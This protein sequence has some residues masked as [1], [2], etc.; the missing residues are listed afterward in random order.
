MSLR[1]RFKMDS[2]P[3]APGRVAPE[4]LPGKKRV[5]SDDNALFSKEEIERGRLQH[6]E[7]SK[8]CSEHAAALQKQQEMK[9]KS[10][11]RAESAAAAGEYIL[12]CK[13]VLNREPPAEPPT[14]VVSTSLK[15]PC[16]R[17]V[18]SPHT[19]VQPLKPLVPVC[20]RLWEED[21][22][23]FANELHRRKAV[24][25]PPDLVGSAL[26]DGAVLEA[27]PTGYKRCQHDYWDNA[28][29][30]KHVA[31]KLRCVA[32]GPKDKLVLQDD[33]GLGAT[34]VAHG[35]FNC[36]YRKAAGVP[37]VDLPSLQGKNEV[38][39]ITRPDL[40]QDGNSRY[41]QECYARRE[42]EISL[43]ASA[44]GIGVHVFAAAIYE[45]VK[46]ARSMKFG[47]F[48][49]LEQAKGD[50]H[51]TLTRVGVTEV[52]AAE[53]AVK[54]VELLFKASQL[55]MVLFDMKP[56]N[57]LVFHDGRV[58]LA[59]FD[60]AFCLV[61]PDEDWR[62]L[63]FINVLLLSCHVR[64]IAIPE[65]CRGW[66]TAVRPL[67]Q[68]MLAR[69]GDYDSSWVFAV[70]CVRLKTD[71]EGSDR[72]RL[73]RMF[74]SLASSYFY[75]SPKSS[76]APS[77][78]YPWKY[79]SDTQLKAFWRENQDS[80]WPSHVDGRPVTPLVEQLVEFALSF[81]PDA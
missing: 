66:Q 80:G 64:N 74:A 55:G 67:L 41:Q 28:D 56:G 31:A 75:P 23:G 24:Q 36:L 63:F 37:V 81:V 76:G 77:H 11:D 33:G 19:A 49:V 15:R 4:G 78:Y 70:C 7:N 51:R 42:L 25:L 16:R 2:R 60:S 5:L 69:R 50:L 47:T 27:T 22:S 43:F 32:H 26:R 52:N 59:D 53:L 45:G 71:Y 54:T 12:Q 1:K 57:V 39:R 73:Q 9:E 79:V 3:K 29:S 6:Q 61:H 17:P 72:F 34:L 14:A 10:R 46:E 35:T 58:R 8:R 30:F 48:S 38:Y 18:P 65:V 44:N 68:Q 13:E 21:G 20:R 62:A 40:D